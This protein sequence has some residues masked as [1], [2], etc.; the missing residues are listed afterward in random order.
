MV[1]VKPL[2]IVFAFSAP[3]KPV[4]ADRTPTVDVPLTLLSP[5]TSNVDVGFVVPIPTAPE[6]TLKNVVVSEISKL[7]TFKLSVNVPVLAVNIPIV[8]IPLT[9]TF[10][11]TS[12][13]DVGTVLPIPTKSLEALYT[14]SSDPCKNPLLFL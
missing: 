14:K 2:L 13:L 12:S 11:N 9:F 5:T 4:V 6:I 8:A 1:V 7:P 3:T 10:P